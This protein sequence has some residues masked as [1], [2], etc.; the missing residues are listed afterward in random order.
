MKASGK[1]ISCAPMSL[2]F[3]RPTAH[4]G[5]PAPLSRSTA[6]RS[7]EPLRLAPITGLWGIGCLAL[8]W[9]RHVSP[10][11]DPPLFPPPASYG[12]CQATEKS[13]SRN[14]K[15]RRNATQVIGILQHEK[16]R[17]YIR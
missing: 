2:R 6:V 16:G 12:V 17:S 5:S 3:W 8:S 9:W 11:G 14:L 15:E 10:V 1:T 13:V 7:H 4:A